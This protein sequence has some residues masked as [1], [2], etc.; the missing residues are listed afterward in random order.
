MLMKDLPAPI[1]NLNL[2]L[3]QTFMLVGDTLSF[4]R[5]AEQ[6]HRSQSAV[7]T[8][9]R[10]LEQQLGI[11]LLY[12]TTRSVTL[13]Q[14]GRELLDGVQRA[15]QEVGLGL[16]KIRESADMKRGRVSLACSPSL[17]ATRLPRILSA[18]KHEYPQVRISLIEQ[19][20]TDIFQSVRQGD[21]DFGIGSVLPAIGDD[22]V[23]EP[24]LDDPIVALVPRSFLAKPRKT[25]SVQDLATM[26]LLLHNAGTAMRQMVEEAFRECA[27]G[28]QSHYQCMQ[29]QTLVAM[30]TAGLGVAILPRSILD[31]AVPASTAA[32]RLVGPSL[33]RKMAL[34]TLR[35]RSLSPTAAGLAQLIRE[36]IGEAG[37]AGR[38][39]RKASAS[40]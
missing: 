15:L 35:G 18:F 30:A 5:A 1:T 10:Q 40:A 39:S 22:I 31:G 27:Q 16:R 29:M 34:I 21:A 9:I 11:T 13:T 12:R 7:S 3:L 24:I 20:S 28:L 14:E 33:T 4:R 32:L 17:A 25:I 19:H 23:F 26:P 38:P 6:C 36:R 8:Q 2:R 37:A